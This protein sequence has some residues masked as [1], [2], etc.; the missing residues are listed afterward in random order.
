MSDSADRPLLSVLIPVYNEE[1]TLRKVV[2]AVQEVPI[3]KEIIL[4]DDG[5]HDGSAQIIDE[6]ADGD[7]VRGYHHAHNMGKGA[8]VRTAVQHARG[9]LVL[10]QDA[11]LEYDPND[12]PA[13]IQP[14]LDGKSDVVFGSRAFSSHT[15][16]SFWF[17]MGNKLVTL[18]TN[19]LFDCYISDM[20]TCYK[21][22]RRE[23]AQKLNL[24]SRGFEIEPEI[25]AKLIRA[26]HRVY[27]VPISYAARSRAEGKKL[28]WQD[29]IK[30][31][32]TLV[33]Y[34]FLD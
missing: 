33:R 5:S 9:D 24:R 34:R 22:M 17:V 13:L 3:D 14:I 2:E 19:V 31:L 27:E 6:L 11:D 30:A 23:I 25:T 28:T 1:R 20:E 7:R 8:A 10:I 21:V 4:V 29:G 15:A 32:R 18:A 16:Y 12:Y 26:G